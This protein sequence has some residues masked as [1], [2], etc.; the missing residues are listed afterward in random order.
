MFD[1]FSILSPSWLWAEMPLTLLLT[2]L[3]AWAVA[4]RR[5]LRVRRAGLT[6]GDDRR[7][8]RRG[9]GSGLIL[10]PEMPGVGTRAPQPA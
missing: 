1:G 2:V 8:H 9:D 3:F 6:V 5:L 10:R 7:D 4:R